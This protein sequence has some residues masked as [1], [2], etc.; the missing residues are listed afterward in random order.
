[1]A[2]LVNLDALIQR[3]DFEVKS[4]Q[5]SFQQNITAIQV[6]RIGNWWF[7]F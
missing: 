4:E 6:R 3:E 7:V 1:M 2:D 5:S